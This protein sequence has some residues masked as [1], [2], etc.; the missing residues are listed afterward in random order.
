M[1]IF[2]NKMVKLIQSNI[3]CSSA[4]IFLS[5][6]KITWFLFFAWTGEDSIHLEETKAKLWTKFSLRFFVGLLIRFFVCLFI[7]VCWFFRSW[8]WNFQFFR[9]FLGF[10]IF[11]LF[12]R[13][14]GNTFSVWLVK[15][16]WKKLKRDFLRVPRIRCRI[17]TETRRRR[18]CRVNSQRCWGL[19]SVVNVNLEE[20]KTYFKTRVATSYFHMR[21]TQCGAFSKI[22]QWL[23]SPRYDTLL[24]NQ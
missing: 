12:R 4:K 9:T 18:R 7:P 6:C 11:L 23:S 21:F 3:V 5:S 10:A 1:F 20:G 15:I 13:T 14:L 16:L 2:N 8:L 17:G 22:L 24:K 19:L